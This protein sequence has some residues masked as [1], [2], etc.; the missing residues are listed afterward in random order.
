MKWISVKDQLPEDNVEVLK[1]KK[2][3]YGYNS[4]L[5]IGCFGEDWDNKHTTHWMP[6]PDFPEES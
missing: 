6:L 3:V 5:I 4:F 2:D 1:F